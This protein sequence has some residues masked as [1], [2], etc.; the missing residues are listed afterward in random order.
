M[1]GQDFLELIRDGEILPTPS[2]SHHSK[3][4]TRVIM[5]SFD[6]E[7]TRFIA[8]LQTRATFD[9]QTNQFVSGIAK[10]DPVLFNLNLEKVYRLSLANQTT[11]VYPKVCWKT[12]QFKMSCS[13]LRI[14]HN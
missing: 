6:R 12:H 8:S 13:H 11:K 1:F 10:L 4:Q 3:D 5:H 7:T 9:D 2:K 14:S